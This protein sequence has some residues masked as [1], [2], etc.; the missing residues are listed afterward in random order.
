MRT[1]LIVLLLAVSFQA[2]A[3]SLP[4]PETP[5][6]AN[7]D[8]TQQNY[9]QTICGKSG[10]FRPPV[11]YTNKIKQVLFDRNPKQCGGRISGCELDHRYPICGGGEPT[12]PKRKAD[13]YKQLWLE[14]YSGYWNAHRKDKLEVQ[15]CKRLCN[16]EITLKQAQK[17]FLDPDW[18]VYYREYVKEGFIHER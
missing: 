5:G 8:I 16:G 14:P 7:P 9:K 10:Q 4:P 11:S 2:V 1:A 13:P 17:V 3:D 6:L 15:V 12:G 18:T